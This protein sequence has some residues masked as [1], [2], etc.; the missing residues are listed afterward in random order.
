MEETTSTTDRV[1]ERREA[2][3]ATGND[4]TVTGNDPTVRG[5]SRKDRGVGRG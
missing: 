3:S 2:P 1:E 4:P 5:G